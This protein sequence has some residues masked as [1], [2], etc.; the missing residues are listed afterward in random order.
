MAHADEV[1]RARRA[2][3]GAA[4]SALLCGL[5]AS[6]P[7]RAQSVP[8]AP[9]EIRDKW[10][11][12]TLQGRT[13]GGA[14]VAMSFKSDGKAELSGAASDTGTWRV[15]DNGYCT[16]WN[17]IRAGQERCFTVRRA[18]GRIEVFNPDGSLSGSFDDLP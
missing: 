1:V 9:A 11:G 18:A 15:S 17:R 5:L 2:V 3:A 7:A 10:S 6:D 4:A 12:R 8:V 13:P 16:T 14:A